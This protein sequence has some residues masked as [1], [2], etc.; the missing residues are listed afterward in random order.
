ML[1]DT[2][3]ELCKLFVHREGVNPSSMDGVN[4]LRD[5]RS[6]HVQVV[7]WKQ[8]NKLNQIKPFSGLLRIKAQTQEQFKDGIWILCPLFNAKYFVLIMS[9]Y[10]PKK[11]TMKLF[12]DNL[13]NGPYLGS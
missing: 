3:K 7:F 13:S 11:V 4:D 5:H 10:R 12:K 6:F 8:K 2:I 9:L 1:W